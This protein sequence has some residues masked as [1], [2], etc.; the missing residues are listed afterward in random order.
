MLLIMV[1][2]IYNYTPLI[3]DKGLFQRDVREAVP[4]KGYK[5]KV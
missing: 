4:Y 5:L 1:K 2:K 3:A